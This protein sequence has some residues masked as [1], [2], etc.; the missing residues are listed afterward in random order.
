MA[1]KVRTGLPVR[2]TCVNPTIGP[3]RNL[4]HLPSVK[5]DRP[6]LEAT[7]NDGSSSPTRLLLPPEPSESRP[8]RLFSV[9]TVVE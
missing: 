5:L 1:H 8:V 7:D 9:R 2:Q 4:H 3:P 6:F